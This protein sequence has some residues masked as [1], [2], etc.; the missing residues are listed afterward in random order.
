[1]TSGLMYTGGGGEME[2]G[3][4]RKQAIKK[5]RERVSR[6]KNG[7]ACKR[8]RLNQYT[9][10]NIYTLVALLQCSAQQNKG[11]FRASWMDPYI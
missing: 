3:E 9:K 7:R 11:F 10:S 2:G 5:E 8:E 6:I 4:R 1:M